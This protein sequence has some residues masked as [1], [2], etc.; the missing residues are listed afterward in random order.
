MS[1]LAAMPAGRLA[2]LFRAG[3]ATPVEAPEALLAKL[4]AAE[5]A[6]DAFAHLDQA[7]AAAADRAAAECHRAGEAPRPLDGVPVSVE[8]MLPTIGKSTRRGSRTTDP[9][10]PQDGDAPA[11]ARLR[12][13][14]AVLYGKTTTTEFGGSPCSTSALT[15]ETR[16]PWS[17]DH[18]CTGSSMGAAAHLAAGVGTMALGNDASESIRMPAGAVG[19]VGR[20][21]A[22]GRVATWLPSV[23]GVLG[24]I[25]PMAADVADAALPLA[26]M[27]GPDPRDPLSAAPFAPLPGPVDG[28]AGLR[29]ACSPTLGIAAPDEAVRA[30]VEEV[31]PPPGGVV[32]AHDCLRIGDRAASDRTGPG[33]A[34]RAEMGELV[35]RV[36]DRAAGHGLDD[37]VA[38]DRHRLALTAAMRGF[39]QR[40]D[41]VIR[42]TLA[43]TAPPLGMRPGPGDAHWCRVEGRIRS[44]YAF[45]F[46][47]TGQ[48]AISVPC[49]LAPGPPRLP[50]GLQVLAAPHRDDLVLRAARAFEAPRPPER[51]RLAVAGG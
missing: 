11:A 23:A 22:L 17:L 20:K 12:A 16:N 3:E 34:R 2:T 30:H 48:S 45:A 39:H 40:F 50:V 9:H 19:V 47:T 14:G 7:G 8:D 21:P 10:A 46:D 43:V 4:D 1:D 6:V 26:A 25:G 38:A 36:L 27:E 51:S 35:A 49:G 13:D 29:V 41:L 37:H 5:P 24:H 15:G 18:A 31:D 42:P 32:G 33:G 28:V 44:P